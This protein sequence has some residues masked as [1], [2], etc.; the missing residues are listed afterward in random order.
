MSQRKTTSTNYRNLEELSSFCGMN[1][2]LNLLSGRWKLL[3]IYKLE[4]GEKRY[5]DLKAVLPNITDRMLALHLRE[6][7]MD[8]LITRH[9][10]A[11]VPPRVEYEL[12][13]IGRQLAPICKQMESWGNTHRDLKKAPAITPSDNGKQLSL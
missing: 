2:A 1:Y 10:Y 8:G 11:G 13:D 4:H 9:L 12:T 5:S 7:E 3:I 6:L